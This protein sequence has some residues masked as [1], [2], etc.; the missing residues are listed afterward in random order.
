[1]RG[2]QP[3]LRKANST[4]TK[5]A[6]IRFAKSVPCEAV[7]LKPD[8]KLHLQTGFAV[9]LAQ[10]QI[11]VTRG[12]QAKAYRLLDLS[13]VDYSERPLARARKQSKDRQMWKTT[14][15]PLDLLEMTH[16]VCTLRFA[17][18][19]VP[20]MLVFEST[21]DLKDFVELLGLHAQGCNDQRNHK[22]SFY[23]PTTV[24]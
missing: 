11:S 24:H 21:D 15:L 5:A 12:K 17:N 1:M 6:Q 13:Q 10:D 3:R 4:R 18:R 22:V 23:Y 20:L 2:A 19:Q 9:R 16:R 8:G 7:V 14:Q